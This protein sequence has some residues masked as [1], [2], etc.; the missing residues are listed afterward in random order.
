[1]IISRSSGSKASV[2]LT[3]SV[4]GAAT[5]AAAL[6][7]HPPTAAAGQEPGVTRPGPAGTSGVPRERLSRPSSPTNGAADQVA[8][9]LP[10]RIAKLGRVGTFL[11][12]GR[13]V[14]V[15][16]ESCDLRGGSPIAN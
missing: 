5:V 12:P 3:R 15:S 4:L 16:A 10:P 8:C 14:G 6:A 1:M 13:I 11:A 2:A 9:R 7:W